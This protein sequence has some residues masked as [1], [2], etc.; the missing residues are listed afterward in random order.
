VRY[1]PTW[2]T[3]PLDD[4]QPQTLD[5][6]E[7]KL[8]DDGPVRITTAPTGDPVMDN[9]AGVLAAT[10]PTDDATPADCAE[11]IQ[12]TREGEYRLP[13]RD[14]RTYCLMT[15]PDRDEP[16]TLVRVDVQRPDDDGEL[17]LRLTAWDAVP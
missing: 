1:T 8:V 4:T 9:T 6:A 11:A 12:G 10:I 2:L 17:K 7:P 16:Q 15:A 5:L 13:L 14:D 3:V